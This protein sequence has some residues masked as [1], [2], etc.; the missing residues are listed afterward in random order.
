MKYISNE[1]S[2]LMLTPQKL[3]LRNILALLFL[4]LQKPL[5]G[6]IYNLKK[7]T[8]RNKKTIYRN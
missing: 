7:E 1:L 6:D 2:R 5:F 8:D 4:Q 3:T